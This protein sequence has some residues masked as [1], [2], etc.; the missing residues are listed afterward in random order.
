MTDKENYGQHNYRIKLLA[1]N[2]V[3]LVEC[4]N[5]ESEVFSP[6][7][8]NGRIT[9]LNIIPNR[10]C[11][12][13]SKASIMNFA[14]KEITRSASSLKCEKSSRVSANECP[15]MSTPLANS[16]P[17]GVKQRCSS[18]SQLCKFYS[19]D[20]A[21]DSTLP[22]PEPVRRAVAADNSAI[23]LPRGFQISRIYHKAADGAQKKVGRLVMSKSSC[24]LSNI[25]LLDGSFKLPCSPLQPTCSNNVVRSRNVLHSTPRDCIARWQKVLTPI[26]TYARK[27]NQ[28]V[29]VNRTETAE[30]MKSKQ[31]NG[32]K[33]V[34]TYLH[35]P[36]KGLD[37]SQ[38]IVIKKCK[39][40]KDSKTKI[41]PR[42]FKKQQDQSIDAHRRKL[43]CS[44]PA[45]S[46]SFH[47]PRSYLET[48]GMSAFDLLTS[49][50]RSRT[51]AKKLQQQFRKGCLNKA[52]ST[53]SKYKMVSTVPPI[54]QD[55]QVLELS[56]IS[57]EEVSQAL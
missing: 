19:R 23:N 6:Q 8:V 44:I 50:N 22:T 36:T 37:V 42:S 29:T 35:N 5:Y 17:A 38:Q 31:K 12:Q 26:R 24:S 53:Y 30:S 54:Q 57:M 49:S 4:N 3:V 25:S 55:E 18:N 32:S 1:S 14:K 20:T 52:S 28:H 11:C 15:A 43:S 13:I 46:L 9:F 10:R 7:I 34:P 41:S 45:H 47:K 16:T 21:S 27:T 51:I 56:R 40:I 48:M 33:F 39:L 2:N